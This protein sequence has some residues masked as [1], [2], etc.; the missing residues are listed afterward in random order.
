MIPK[1]KVAI[2]S[3]DKGESAWGI[4]AISDTEMDRI[5]LGAW[6]GLYR[7][8]VGQGGQDRPA[9]RLRTSDIPDYDGHA[10]ARHTS[11]TEHCLRGCHSGK[12]RTIWATASCS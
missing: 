10:S 3:W 1:H 11:G 5:E 7:R 4:H 8:L 2:Q 12:D 9:G 6:C